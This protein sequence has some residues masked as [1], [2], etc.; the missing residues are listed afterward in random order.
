MTKIP[1]LLLICCA[2]ILNLEECKILFSETRK[3]A[4]I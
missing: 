4:V 3:L 2:L 1:S